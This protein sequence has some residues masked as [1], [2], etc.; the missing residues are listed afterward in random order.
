M[1][2][3]AMLSSDIRKVKFIVFIAQITSICGRRCETRIRCSSPGQMFHGPFH[4]L[5]ISAA[6]GIHHAEGYGV[7]RLHKRV[8]EVSLWKNG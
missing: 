2:S 6:K 1:P 5:G 7:L 3:A 8:S 4:L